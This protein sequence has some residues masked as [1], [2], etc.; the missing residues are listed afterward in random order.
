[1]SLRSPL[2]IRLA[3]ATYPASILDPISVFFDTTMPGGTALIS[4]TLGSNLGTKR[5]NDFVTVRTEVI[6]EYEQTIAQL[7]KQL[8]HYRQLVAELVGSGERHEEYGEPTAVVPVDP[9]S[10]RVINS[11]AQ[12]RIPAS[13]TFRDFDEGEL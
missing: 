10:I 1:L 2:P 8:L 7:R 6:L 5:I 4:G 3:E 13:A 12:A 9:A 11:I